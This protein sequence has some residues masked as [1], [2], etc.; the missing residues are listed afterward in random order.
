M[1]Q[2]RSHP[3]SDQGRD[4][5][6]HQ[7]E[8]IQR[9]LANTLNT[10]GDAKLTFQR[11]R[12]SFLQLQSS[13]VNA[14]VSLAGFNASNGITIPVGFGLL[15]GSIVNPLNNDVVIDATLT[16]NIVFRGNAT[17]Q[18]RTDSNGVQ[19]SSS[20][21]LPVNNAI[22]L[23]NS[24]IAEIDAGYRIFQITNPDGASG[25]F[26]IYIGDPASF[27][28]QVF[29]MSNSLIACR[30]PLEAGTLQ[31]KFINTVVDTD[32]VFARNG[33]EYFRL[34]DVGYPLLNFTPNTS[35]AGIPAE[36]QY[37]NVFGNRGYV[38]TVFVG[39][40]VAGNACIE[41][42]RYDRSAENTF[43]DNR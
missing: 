33:V 34:Q 32:L 20:L 3:G 21:S 22:S 42:M 1:G 26:R 31:T 4:G 25:T 39:A 27:G 29:W 28:N 35:Q 38:D 19:L 6:V 43:C 14:V 37:A 2:H 5:P 40:T 15:T 11:N 36:Y 41:Y 13:P 12:L 30:K 16:N 8:H 9:I 24:A 23:G 18:M 10:I 7:L 17:E